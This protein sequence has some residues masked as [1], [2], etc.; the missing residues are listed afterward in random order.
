M[1][2]ARVIGLVLAARWRLVA[3]FVAAGLLGMAIVT[4]LLERRYTATV[5][6]HVENDTPH[7]T[8]IDQVAAQPSYLESVEYFQDQ[9]G[10]LK[11][12][13]LM[14]AVI[15]DLGLRDDPHFKPQPPGLVARVAGVAAGLVGRLVRPA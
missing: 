14:A 4:L 5:V 11:S 2:Q 7:V 12:R 13:T 10:L 15:R 3:A 8:K 6:V 9:V 1:P